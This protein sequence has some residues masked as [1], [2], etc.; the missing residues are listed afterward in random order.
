MMILFED[1]ATEGVNT[2][3]EL[4]RICIQ[5]SISKW[6]AGDHLGLLDAETLKFAAPVASK[7]ELPPR[8]SAS[9]I[10]QIGQAGDPVATLCDSHRSRVIPRQHQFQTTKKKGMKWKER[11]V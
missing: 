11:K 2:D 1:C 10:T 8:P 4:C 5:I 9:N 7:L 6:P 3:S